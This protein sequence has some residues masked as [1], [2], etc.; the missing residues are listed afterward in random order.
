M[1]LCL[2]TWLT[3]KTIGKSRMLSILEIDFEFSLCSC[4]FSFSKC[5]MKCNITPNIIGIS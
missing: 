5:K 2:L 3:F 1:S 4:L